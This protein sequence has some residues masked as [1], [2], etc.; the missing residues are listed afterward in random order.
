MTLPL[1]SGCGRPSGS[2]S[3]LTN[4][5]PTTRGPASTGTRISSPASPRDLHVL[6]P[7]GIAGKAGFAVAGVTGRGGPALG[8]ASDGEPFQQLAIEADVEL[9]RPPHALEVILILPLE[10]NLDEVLAVDG[11]VVAN[12]DAAARSERQ[13]FALPVVLQHVQR[14]LEC[15]ESRTG[16]RKARREPRDLT[17][18]RHVSLQVGRRNRE[19]IR[20]VVETA[21][22]CLVPGQQRLHIEVEREQVAN[23][24][25]VFRAIETMDRV[26]PAWI[27]TGRP[28][29][30]DFAFQRAR[31]RRDTW[32]HRAAAF[33]AAASSRPEAWRSRAPT[34]P[35]WRLAS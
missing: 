12:R 35:H 23:R 8:S 5:T 29:P 7:F 9:L 22:R 6:F 24:V 31:L 4:D 14:D 30:V 28:R 25:V 27:R 19:D 2:H 16:G 1:C 33:R 13:I 10:T 34:P 3:S 18:H 11:K 26:D 17:R 32:P 15:L 21:V 20:E